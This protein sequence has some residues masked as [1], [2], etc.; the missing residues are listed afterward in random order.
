M[1]GIDPAILAQIGNSQAYPGSP[2]SPVNREG[3]PGE[4]AA[5]PSVQE[6]C[7]QVCAQLAEC[8]SAMDALQGAAEMADE[9]DPATEQMIADAAGK[10]AEANDAM[11]QVMSTLS[12]GGDAPAAPPG[13][14]AGTPPKAPPPA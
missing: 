6:Q 9:M 12:G 11:T 14:P 3:S 1:P 10:V 13:G 7:E 5:E 2:A 8:A 4:G